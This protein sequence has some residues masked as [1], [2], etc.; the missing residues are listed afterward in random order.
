[1]YRLMLTEL[2]LKDKSCLTYSF[3]F[4]HLLINLVHVYNLLTPIKTVRIHS[5]RNC[6][7]AQTFEHTTQFPTL[8]CLLQET[9]IFVSMH[10]N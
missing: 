7:K 1:M 2:R 8:I 3:N 5:F 4:T 6:N 9:L 10:R